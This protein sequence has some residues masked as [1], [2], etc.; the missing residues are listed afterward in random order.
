MDYSDYTFLDK[1]PVKRLLQRRRLTDAL[2]YF[3]ASGRTG[4]VLDFG[5]GNGELSRRIAAAY[6]TAI[7]T[8]YEP[9]PTFFRQAQ[10]I[11]RAYPNITM[12]P[13]L[14]GVPGGSQDVVYALEVF[15]HLPEPQTAEALQ[16]IRERL[17]TDGILIIGVPIE[18]GPPALFKGIFRMA[19]RYGDFDAR[20]SNVARATAAVPPRN[21]PMVE[22]DDCLPYYPHHLGFD[23][24]RLDERVSAYFPLLVTFCSPLL[25][26]GPAVNSE[27]YFVARNSRRVPGFDQSGRNG[28]RAEFRDAQ[29][30]IIDPKYPSRGSRCQTAGALWCFT[31][32]ASARYLRPC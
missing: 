19:R 25:A 10:K 7:V 18:I 31:I 2:K 6:P 17:R 28:A 24:R 26:F 22:L 29:T 16:A 9:A 12:T 3:P 30:Q 5:A 13:S 20:P 8:C 27:I 14:S 23:H 15:E 32:P 4:R 11:T 1:S 21:R